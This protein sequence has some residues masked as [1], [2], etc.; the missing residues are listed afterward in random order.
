MT[1]K[2]YL[3]TEIWKDASWE[4]VG[5]PE[6]RL[7]K[8]GFT[9]KI[10]DLAIQDAQ[11]NDYTQEL[12]S[13]PF[14]SL[15]IVAYDLDKTNKA[16]VNRLNALAANLTQ[17]FNTRTLLLTA[18]AP[19]RAAAFAKEYKLASEIFY[20]DAVPLKSMVRANPGVILLKNGNIVNKWHFHT[21]PDYDE[22]VKDYFGKQ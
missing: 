21:V 9:P 17:N 8:K 11:R 5:N 15:V 22:L 18:A 7:V 4:I 20:A 13:N 3:K 19:A 2:E 14:Y 12:L 6:S 16:A 1:D 10:I